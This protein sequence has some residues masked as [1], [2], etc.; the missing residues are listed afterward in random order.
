MQL[1]EEIIEKLDKL[2][3]SF[4]HIDKEFYHLKQISKSY[5]FLESID[6]ARNTVGMKVKLAW[7]T[8]HSLL[9]SERIAYR[10][11]GYVWLGGLLM[12]EID[13]EK[14]AIWSNIKKFQQNISL[15][16]VNAY[17]SSLDVPLSIWL[18]CGILK[19]KNNLTRWGFLYVLDRLLMRCKFLLDEHKLQHP[20]SEALER[21][22]EKSRLEKANAVI[23]IMSTALSLEAQINETDRLNILKV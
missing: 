7:A 3:H 21:V 11:N 14:D 18:W 17:S 9:H 22:H 2:V 6:D 23:D 19:S 1:L 16:G 12:A 4:T 5:G 8:L 20:S 15:A 13:E 10:Q